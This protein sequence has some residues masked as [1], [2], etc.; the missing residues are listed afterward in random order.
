MT[1]QPTPAR[2]PAAPPSDEAMEAARKAFPCSCGDWPATYGNG[3]HASY[4]LASYAYACAL[5]LDAYRRDGVEGCARWHEE[6]A[7]ECDEAE[8]MDAGSCGFWSR[9]ARAHR[10]DAACIRALAARRALDAKDSQSS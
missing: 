10:E 8:K 6:R 5:A 4:C 3:S 9:R 7:A 1:N 2:G